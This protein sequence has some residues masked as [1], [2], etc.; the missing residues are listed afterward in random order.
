MSIGAA[1]YLY[2]SAISADRMPKVAVGGTFDPFHDG[3]LALLRKA[4]EVAGPRGLVVIALTSDEMA[5]RTRTRPVAKFEVRLRNLRKRLKKELGVDHFEVERIH[6]VFG[7][8]IED[9]YDYI[10]V[11]P[12]TESM[13]CQIN[14][15]RREN[16]LAS[17]IVV[18]IEYQMA[19]DQIRI[20]STRITEGKIDKHGKVLV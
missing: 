1:R 11:S 18:R 10:I 9:D 20:S 19:D 4:F 13:A 3:H 16:G 14:E 12:E 8:A 6:D 15:I 2:R 17:L 7:S 5:T